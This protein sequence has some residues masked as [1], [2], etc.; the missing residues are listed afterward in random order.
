MPLC[1]GMQPF[2]NS[3]KLLAM[4]CSN[5]YFDIWGCKLIT[6]YPIIGH[7]TPDRFEWLVTDDRIRSIVLPADQCQKCYVTMHVCISIAHKA[8]WQIGNRLLQPQVVTHRHVLGTCPRTTRIVL[9]TADYASHLP[10]V[11][12]AEGACDVMQWWASNASVYNT[13][14]ITTSAVGASVL[15]CWSAHQQASFTPWSRSCGRDN[16]LI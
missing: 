14:C 16:F 15:S 13:P 6:R 4:S 3:S 5:K 11:G 1:I 8:K 2:S 7:I 12:L 10:P 9:P